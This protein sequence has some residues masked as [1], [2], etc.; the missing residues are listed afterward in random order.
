MKLAQIEVLLLQ[1][2][3]IIHSIILLPEY[4]SLSHSYYRPRLRT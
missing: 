2:Y 4:F 3:D 1:N